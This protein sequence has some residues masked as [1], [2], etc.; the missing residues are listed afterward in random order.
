MKLNRTYSD[1]PAGHSMTQPTFQAHLDWSF[2]SCHGPPDSTGAWRAGETFSLWHCGPGSVKNTERQHVSKIGD[3]IKRYCY[4]ESKYQDM[5]QQSS[6]SETL[7]SW[8]SFTMKLIQVQGQW[9]YFMWENIQHQQLPTEN[10]E[11]L[12]CLSALH[13][14]GWSLRN[15]DSETETR[16]SGRSSHYEILEKQLSLWTFPVSKV[17][18][19]RQLRAHKHFRLNKQIHGNVWNPVKTLAALLSF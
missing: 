7:A 13:W 18:C 10:N 1:W 15:E 6:N 3:Q 11:A 16:I 8:C 14:T 5:A 19:S 12:T 9:V 4:H 17:N 2:S